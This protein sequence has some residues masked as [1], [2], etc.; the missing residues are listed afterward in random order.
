MHIKSFPFLFI[1][2]GGTLNFA[3]LPKYSGNKVGVYNLDA[4][5]TDADD[6]LYF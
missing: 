6:S 5:G 1:L 4:E 3:E 2:S